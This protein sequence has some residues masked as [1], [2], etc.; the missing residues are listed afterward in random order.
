MVLEIHVVDMPSGL[1]LAA[2]PPGAFIGLGV[3]IAAKNAMALRQGEQPG[4]AAADTHANP[5]PNP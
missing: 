2:L 1:L 3:L 5:A 4:A